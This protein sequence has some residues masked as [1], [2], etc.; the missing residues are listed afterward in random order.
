V[1]KIFHSTKPAKKPT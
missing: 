1:A